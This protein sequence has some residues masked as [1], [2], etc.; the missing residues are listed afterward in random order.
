MK[1]R[2]KS[3]IVVGSG[4]VLYL[5]ATGLILG[6]AIYTQANLLFWG[7]GLMV[8]GG[9]VSVVLCL[10]ALRAI[11]IQ[12]LLPGH[13]V[14]GEPCVLRYHISNRSWLPIFSVFISEAWGRTPRFRRRRKAT[15]DPEG[16]LGGAPNGWIMHV[17]PQQSLQAEALCWPRR[18][19][20]LKFERIVV[21]TSFPFGILRKIVE[22]PEAGEV[23]VYPALHRLSRR[24]LSTLARADTTGRKHIDRAGGHEEFFGLREYRY[25]D[26]LKL[27]DWKHTA[28]LKKLVAREM[29]LPSPPR[30]MVMLDLRDTAQQRRAA[31]DLPDAPARPSWWRRLGPHPTPIAPSPRQ[32]RLDSITEAEERAIS[33]TASVLC[34]A[35][36]HGYQVGMGVQGAP[37]RTFPVHHSLPHRVRLLEALSRLDPT[38][39]PG[40]GDAAAIEPSVVIHP[41][42][43]EQVIQNGR[44]P[45]T[46]LGA[47]DLDQ[48]VIDGVPASAMLSSRE[49]GPVS[50]RVELEERA[51]Q[52]EAVHGR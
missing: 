26:S 22:V 13:A 19:G 15:G 30:I 28:R 29:T 48:L 43:G 35:Y 45:K 14:C 42:R 46:L 40:S 34:D 18:R 39:G 3:R 21:S 50:R 31:M 9:A 11:R 33:L 37:C 44:W 5:I 4:G 51:V 47:A 38:A 25:G 32:V 23:I 49:A 52:Q 16:R 20:P 8:G 36:F 12:R 1:Q 6:A 7:F 2:R 10:S 41:G 17:G 24:T 27:V